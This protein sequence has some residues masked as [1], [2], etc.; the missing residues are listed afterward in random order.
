M[1]GRLRSERGEFSL[2]GLLVAMTVFLVILGATLTLYSTSETVS[3]DTQLRTDAQDKARVAEETISKQLRNLASPPGNL[4]SAT[5][6]D[7]P[8]MLS[9]K[10]DYD[11]VFATIEPAAPGAGVTNQSNVKRVRYCL[12][13]T[14]KLWRQ[15]QRW[16]ATDPGAPPA[17]TACPVASLGATGTAQWQTSLVVAGY[18]ANK[19]DPSADVPVFEYNSTDPA[20]VSQ[21]HV[22]LLVDLDVAK[23][24]KGTTI[25]TGVN[26]RNQNR[27]PIAVMTAPRATAQGIFLNGSASTDPEGQPLKYC[28]ID[29]ARTAVNVDPE[30]NTASRC[31][32]GTVGM[33]PTFIYTPPAPVATRNLKLAVK[34]PI[35]QWASD[36][37]KAAIG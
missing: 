16:T 6:I 31:P 17:S 3:R 32:A 5:V 29:V 24:P 20:G 8:Q 37:P 12:D 9:T 28:W 4:A 7:R 35:D 13:D 27:V 21:I 19:L 1:R 18:V 11:L 10:A 36:G 33:G 15:E 14:G 30:T 25:S 2:P 26:L 23:R 34:D 22:N